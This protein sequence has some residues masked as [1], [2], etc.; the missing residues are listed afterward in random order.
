[1]K[2]ALVEPVYVK[3][4]FAVA[5][6]PTPGAFSVIALPLATGVICPFVSTEME[7]WANEG[8]ASKAPRQRR[9]RTRFDRMVTLPSEQTTAWPAQCPGNTRA[10]SSLHRQ[11]S[12]SGSK[13]DPRSSAGHCRAATRPTSRPYRN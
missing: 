8:I 13:K 2:V 1:E 3:V 10:H 4:T 12:G 6:W 7:N 11:R 9:K 5:V